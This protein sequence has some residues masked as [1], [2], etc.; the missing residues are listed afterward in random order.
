LQ[1]YLRPTAPIAGDVILTADPGLAMEIAQRV[2]VKPLMANHHHGLWGYSGRTEAGI[3]LTVQSGG[4]GAPST[5]AVAGELAAHGARRLVRIGTCAAL[6]G[7][8]AVGDVVVVAS[9]LGADGTSAALEADVAWPDRAVRERL[10]GLG[11]EV[12]VASFDLGAAAGPAMKMAWTADGIA[13]VDMETA[14][15]FA[16]AERSG[17]AAAAALVVAEAATGS[18]SDEAVV[19]EALM[20]TGE[21]AAR[22]LGGS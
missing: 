7:A 17:M 19:R 3:A 4:I 2:L 16:V 11:S 12:A 14:A 5:A 22:A 18:E 8:L 15:L 21:A 6:D 20:G 9:A 1:P 13:A 10:A